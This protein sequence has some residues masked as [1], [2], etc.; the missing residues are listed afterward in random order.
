MGS[1]VRTELGVNAQFLKFLLTYFRWLWWIR[2]RSPFCSM[3]G[4]GFLYVYKGII[5]KVLGCLLV[6]FILIFNNT[7]RYTISMLSCK[8]LI[9]LL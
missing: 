4:V 5:V 2:W 3:A 7:L 9:S 8:L 1:L 6:E